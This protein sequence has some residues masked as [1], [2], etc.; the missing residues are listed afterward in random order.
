MTKRARGAL[1]A[2]S[3]RGVQFHKR[4]RPRC[5]SNPVVQHLS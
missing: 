5:I 2:V 1:Q 4:Q 3:L